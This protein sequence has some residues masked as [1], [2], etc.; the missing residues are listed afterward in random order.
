MLRDNLVELID[1]ML[2]SAGADPLLPYIHNR[3]QA[4]DDRLPNLKTPRAEG[5]KFSLSESASSPSQ[6]EPAQYQIRF[7]T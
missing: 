6:A 4:S 5:T 2:N 1:A 3:T 7:G